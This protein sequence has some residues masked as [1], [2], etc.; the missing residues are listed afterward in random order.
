MR[1]LTVV[2]RCD[3]RHLTSPKTVDVEK[4][5]VPL[6]F[7]GGPFPFPPLAESDSLSERPHLFPDRGPPLFPGPLYFVHA[8]HYYYQSRTTRLRPLHSQHISKAF[9]A[10]FSLCLSIG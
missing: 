4:D 5:L 7:V 1:C 2:V 6:R 10:N 8:L 3:S 9:S